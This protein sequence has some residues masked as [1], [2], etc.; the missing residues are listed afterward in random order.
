MPHDPN[1]KRVAAGRLNRAKRGPLT[2]EGRERLRVAALISKPWLCATGPRTVEGKA[3][4][5]ANGRYA[6]VA[7]PSIRESR[8]E[9]AELLAVVASP[10]GLDATG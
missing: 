1:P 7:G 9:V 2:G 6:Q 8:R 5:A 4:S 3:A 10:N